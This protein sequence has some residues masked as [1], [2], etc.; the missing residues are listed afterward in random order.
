ML[1]DRHVLLL[2]IVRINRRRNPRARIVSALVGLRTRRAQEGEEEETVTF[3]RYTFIRIASDWH[4]R[5]KTIRF[6]FFFYPI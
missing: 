5:R 1:K 3:V 2:L 6:F 4:E